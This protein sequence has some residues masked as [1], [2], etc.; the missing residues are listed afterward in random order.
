MITGETGAGKSII[1]DA[2]CLTLGERAAGDLVRSGETEAV[3]EA[4]FDVG[5]KQLPRSARRFLEDSGIDSSDGLILKRIISSQ[6]RS[7][8]YIN[9]SMVT[10]QALSDVSSKIIDVHGQYEHQSL[11]SPDNQLDMLDA[12]GGLLSDRQEVAKLH[13]NLLALKHQISGLI[14]K[15]K[16]RARRLDILKYQT[17]EIEAAGLR[18]GE[19]EELAEELRILSSAGR[20]A[21]L[22]NE[23]HES[24]Y[25]SDT[26]CITNLTKILNS[27]KEIRS[28]DTRADDAVKSVESALPL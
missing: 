19:E 16:D 23:A 27:L 10:V 9:G 21:E 26:A 6:G 15:D 22:A 3:V 14:Q 1:I 7:R 25:S 17:S 24:L 2:L 28:I 13:E 5:P 20:L 4:F 18:P 12:Y 8:A 11:L